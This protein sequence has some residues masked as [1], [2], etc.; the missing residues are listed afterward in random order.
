MDF[1]INKLVIDDEDHK[2][3]TGDA[4]NTKDLRSFDNNRWQKYDFHEDILYNEVH[5][6][7]VDRTN[8]K[9]MITYCP[10]T[11]GI[12]SYAKT[13]VSAFDGYSWKQYT[14]WKYLSDVPRPEDEIL[15]EIVIDHNNI[16][17]FKTISGYMRF[18]G[19][20]WSKDISESISVDYRLGSM[21][22][23]TNNVKWFLIGD[24]SLNGYDGLLRY[25]GVGI[26]LYPFEYDR[27]FQYMKIDN[28]N[29][30]WVITWDYL[31][32]KT[33]YGIASFD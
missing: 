10:P 6:V 33:I 13:D 14:D 30:I 18:D 26:S 22:I 16:K 2:W 28:N 32:G 5:L 11:G 23:D 7:T 25:D 20:T 8:V 3:T 9:W 24:N 12:G 31:S 4:W 1:S 19:T 15:R 21:V 29:I 27:E 17:W